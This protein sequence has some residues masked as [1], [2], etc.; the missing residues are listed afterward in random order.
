MKDNERTKV[1]ID[2]FQTRLAL[3][4]G[5]YLVLFLVVLVNFL[6]AWRLWQEGPGDLGEQFARMLRDHLPVGICLLVLVPVMA[7]D[8]IRFSH[9]IVGPMVRFRRTMQAIARGETVRPIKLRKDDYLNDLRDD[10]NQMLEALQRATS[11]CSS[12]PIRRRTKPRNEPRPDVQGPL[13]PRE[14]RSCSSPLPTRRLSRRLRQGLTGRPRGA[15]PAAAAGATMMEYLV[16][17]SF[18]LVVCIIGINYFGQ[19]TKK[20]TEQAGQSI[21]KA[22]E[23]AG[24]SGP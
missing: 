13:R 8:A 15:R 14:P 6:F 22:T 1:W 23:N 3:R 4:I 2:Q 16:A 17:I 18:I 24:S 12:R 5:L 21:E 7:W 19:A 11:P 10:F 9:R 20:L